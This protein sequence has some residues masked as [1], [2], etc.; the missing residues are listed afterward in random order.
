MEKSCSAYGPS[1]NSVRSNRQNPV[2]Q[3]KNGVFSVKQ[4]FFEKI[5]K[6]FKKPIDKMFCLWYTTRS[7]RCN[8]IFG[9]LVERQGHKVI[10]SKVP[11]FIELWLTDCNLCYGCNS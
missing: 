6:I 4:N 10:V 1:V 11:I 5:E 7:I 9:K 8:L 3:R 2:K